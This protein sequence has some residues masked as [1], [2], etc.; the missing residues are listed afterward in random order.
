MW[1]KIGEVLTEYL[2]RLSEQ[3]IHT[4]GRNW[5]LAN[6]LYCTTSIYTA[7][8]ESQACQDNVDDDDTGN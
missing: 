2:N 5:I 6:Y 3:Y 1:E 8:L 7:A 4:M